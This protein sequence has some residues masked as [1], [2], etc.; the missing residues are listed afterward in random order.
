MSVMFVEMEVNLLS[1]PTTLPA[2]PVSE[3]HEVQH[4]LENSLIQSQEEQEDLQRQQA[5]L[6]VWNSL[7]GDIQQLHEL[8]VEFDKVVHVTI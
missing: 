2:S 3:N 5:C 7:Q 1:P 4:P 6:H 8:F